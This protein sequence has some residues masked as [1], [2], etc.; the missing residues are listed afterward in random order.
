MA[1]PRKARP[2]VFKAAEA[3]DYEGILYGLVYAS[4]EDLNHDKV[5]AWLLDVVAELGRLERCRLQYLSGREA[6]GS[7]GSTG[8]SPPPAVLR[9]LGELAGE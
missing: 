8:A 9:L 7:G 6:T 4:G 5:P 3:R 1:T 2:H